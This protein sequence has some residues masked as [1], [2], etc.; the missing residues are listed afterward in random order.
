[1]NI[2]VVSDTHGH[3]EYA[4]AAVRMLASCDVQL[5]IHCGDI[6]SVEMVGLFQPWPTHFVLG[7]VDTHPREMAKAIAEAGQAYHGR[8]GELEVGG[9]LIAFLHGD[10]G[11]LLAATISGGRY[12]LVCY[13][14][15]HVAAQEQ[16]G[17]TLALNPGALYRAQPHSIAIVTLPQLE[18]THVAL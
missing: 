17:R 10:D 4:R 3:L 6:G 1:M 12:D 9:K 13:G 7:N 16:H 8:F 2:G 18:V 14:H 5:V 15:T 11:P